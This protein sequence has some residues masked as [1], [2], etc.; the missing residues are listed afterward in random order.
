MVNPRAFFHDRFVT[1]MLSVNSFLLVLIIVSIL[2]R[3]GDTGDGYV[4]Q[5]R[6][7]LGLD[8]YR[9]S[10][11]KE[12]LSF[13]IFAIIVFSFQFVLGVRMHHLSKKM[14]HAI[15]LLTSVLLIL[16]LLV[17]YSLLGLR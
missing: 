11:I 4:V 5:Y 1:L 16:A 6:A 2:L 13:I 12:I 8:G 3:L 10:D 15:L 17:S 7:N 9:V 14:T